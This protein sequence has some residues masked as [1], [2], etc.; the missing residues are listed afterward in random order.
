[1]NQRKASNPTTTP[2][3][4]REYREEPAISNPK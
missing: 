3:R 4:K 2:I 1:M